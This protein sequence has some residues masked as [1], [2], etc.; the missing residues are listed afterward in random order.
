MRIVNSV[1]CAARAAR[2]PS[3]RPPAPTCPSTG[4][5]SPVVAQ[6]EQLARDGLAIT[7]LHS[8]YLSRKRR[9]RWCEERVRVATGARAAG[10]A[11]AVHVV[12]SFILCRCV[13]V[14]DRANVLDV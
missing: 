1:M 7:P 12:L 9:I 5:V 2:S 3:K 11:D 13:E 10:T 14:D 4:P 8:G 6:E